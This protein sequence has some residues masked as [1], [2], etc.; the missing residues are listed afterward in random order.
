MWC[1]AYPATLSNRQV[2]ISLELKSF[3]MRNFKYMAPSVVSIEYSSLFDKWRPFFNHWDV[4]VG[5]PSARQNKMADCPVETDICEGLASRITGW[6]ASIL[7]RMRFYK[8]LKLNFLFFFKKKDYLGFEWERRGGCRRRKISTSRWRFRPVWRCVP[9]RP[10][11]CWCLWY[12]NNSP[13]FL[14]TVSWSH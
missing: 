14:G 1:W 7:N 3:L 5:N 11:W 12:G 10:N 4:G 8:N 13:S 9:V 6:W 2:K